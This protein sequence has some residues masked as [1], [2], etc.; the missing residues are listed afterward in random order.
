MT[1]D[2]LIVHDGLYDDPRVIRRTALEEKYGES[3]SGAY[4]GRNATTRHIDPSVVALFGRLVG[5]AIKIADTDAFGV[6]RLSYAGDPC[7]NFIHA[8]PVRWG[9][10][11]YLNEDDHPNNGTAFWRHRR[12][13][14]A[15]FPWTDWRRYGFRSQAEAWRALVE[16]DGQ[17]ESKWEQVRLV[18]ARF[19]RVILFDSRQ[20]HSH[21][22]KT[23]FGTDRES[24]RLVQVFFFTVPGAAVAVARQ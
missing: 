10:V 1:A 9:A 12:T 20:F 11:A 8:D 6:Y 7:R 23:N 16:Q 17:D 3:E 15:T 2:S 4:A 19:N 21:M 14:L 22:P 18:P 5:G 13:G 24:A